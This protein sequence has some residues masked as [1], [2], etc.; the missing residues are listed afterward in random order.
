MTALLVTAAII[1]FFPEE[2]RAYAAGGMAILYCPGGLWALS[3]FKARL[4]N[5]R[6]PFSASV[7]EI[8]KD[9]EWLLK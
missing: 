9:R 3:K 7:D 4:K 5:R 2:W 6:I 8:K 1:L